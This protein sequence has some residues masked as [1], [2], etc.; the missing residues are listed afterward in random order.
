MTASAT[1]RT[2]I[3]ARASLSTPEML[4]SSVLRARALIRAR[5]AATRAQSLGVVMEISAS[6]SISVSYPAIASAISR[7]SS[8]RSSVGALRKATL[9]AALLAPRVVHHHR[10][11]RGA[12]Q[13]HRD[14]VQDQRTVAVGDGALTSDSMPHRERPPHRRRTVS[15]GRPAHRGGPGAQVS[16]LVRRGSSPRAQGRAAAHRR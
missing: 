6:C 3:S 2:S 5:T 14:D 10:D 11:H 12:D 15:G 1:A 8:L 9:I 7:T 16:S 13:H 4:R